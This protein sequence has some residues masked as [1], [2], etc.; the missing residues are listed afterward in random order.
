[1]PLVANEITQTFFDLNSVSDTIVK[2]QR[3]D[4][5]IRVLYS[6]TACIV[7]ADQINR[8]FEMFEALYFEGTSIGFASL[9]HLI[10]FHWMAV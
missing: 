1:M 5:P 6:E 7:D 10:Q 9:V 8:T 4:M 2:F 3:Q